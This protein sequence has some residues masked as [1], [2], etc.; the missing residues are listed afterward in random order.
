M[1]KRKPA[2]KLTKAKF[3]AR[4]MSSE[5]NL[6]RVI[7]DL[8]DQLHAYE[9]KYRMRSEIFIKIIVGTPA[10]DQEDFLAWATCYRQYFR[11]LQSQ[12]SAERVSANV[13]G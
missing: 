10:E 6:E 2:L 8:V 12:V 9:K 4:A 11:V 5:P 13:A 7:D 3:L 1:P